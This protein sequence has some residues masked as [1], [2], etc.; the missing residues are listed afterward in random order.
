MAR[1]ARSFRSAWF[2]DATRPLRREPQTKLDPLRQIR[3][4]S[5][6]FDRMDVEAR[7]LSREAAFELL[8]QDLP[9]NVYMSVLSLDKQLEILQPFTNDRGLL[10][11]AVD[12]ATSGAYTQYGIDSAQF[13]SQLE[14]F[15][16]PNQ[17]G[18]QDFE[19][20]INSMTDPSQGPDRAMAMALLN[21]LRMDERTD[22][23]ESG[24]S[25]IFGLLAAVKGQ[26]DLPG[27]KTILYFSTGFVIPQ[28]SEEV[29][30]NVISTANRFNVSFYTFDTRGLTT[31]SLNQQATSQLAAAAGASASG[32]LNGNGISKEAALSVDTAL[33]SG[34]Y[35]TQDTLAILADQ[36][37]GFLVANTNDF[38]SPAHK[39]GEDIQT[40]YE[41]TYSPQ[42]EKYDGAFRKISVK[43][44]R[45]DLHVQSRAGYFA[46]PPSLMKGGGSLDP[47]ELPLLGA[48]G[49]TPLPHAFD[50]ES[51]ALHFRGDGHDQ[52][53]G[54][55][56]DLPLKNITLKHDIPSGVYTGGL[57]YE[58]LIKNESGEVVKKLHGDV[59]VSLRQDQLLSF[60][61]S[62]FSDTEYFDVPAGRYTI[63]T[64]ALD[65]QTGQTSARKSVLV[66]P[67]SRSVLA[68][69]SVALIRSWKPKEPDAAADDPF[70]YDG[71]SM[72]PTLTPVVSKAGSTALPLYAAIY[73]DQS[74]P[75]KP[76]VTVQFIRDGKV[77]QVGLLT[78]SVPLGSADSDGRIQ[79]V[80]NAPIA[81]FE[82]GNYEVRLVVTQGAETAQESLALN[83]EP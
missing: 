74:N 79:Y 50:F 2:R 26:Y 38:R 31:A 67:K 72:T 77:R 39:I 36:T 53:M 5:L 46:L 64:A 40:Y 35:N 57:V 19:E 32:G 83:L 13:R 37:G 58:A 47:Y 61:Q 51:G 12:H 59:P 7:R 65:K 48:L 22:L 41:L 29:F 70:V 60:Q 4:V 27:R 15:T 30:K 73:P 17:S 6:I 69:S 11:K 80:A 14:Q 63:E 42:I 23:S 78:G 43:T 45:S 24:R 82:P 68:L 20:R 33:D 56:I 44:S 10:T 18:Q 25:S 81:Q 8:K 75:A 21:M 1:S 71:K 55:L 3:L 16:G 34:K 49:S 9:Q 76:Q 54:F 62:R 66:V 28:G 52:V